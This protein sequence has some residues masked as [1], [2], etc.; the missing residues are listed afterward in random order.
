MSAESS[1]RLKKSTKLSETKN[2]WSSVRLLTKLDVPNEGPVTKNTDYEFITP[3][4][5]LHIDTEKRSRRKG[6][7]SVSLKL[8]YYTCTLTHVTP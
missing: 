7:H 6:C 1:Y 5:K 2:R 3:I 4:L 8:H